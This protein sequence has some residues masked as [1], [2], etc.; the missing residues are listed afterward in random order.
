MDKEYA[1]AIF[2]GIIGTQNVMLNEP[3]KNHTSFRVGGPVDLL[4]TPDSMDNLVRIFEIC[5]HEQLPVFIMGNGT[6]L[7]VR[8]KGIRGIVIKMLD[9]LSSYKVLD[10]TI[11]AEAGILISRLSKIAYEHGLSGMEFAEGIPGTLGGAVTMNAGA[12][13]GEIADVLVR[14]RYL[15]RDGQVI[16]LEKEQ[17]RFGKRESFIQSDGG[18]VLE[19]E[20]KLKKGEKAEIKALM[21]S[22]KKQRNDKQP[23]DLPSAGS[24]FKRPDG[25]FAGKLVQDCG[26][27][28]FRIG[29]AE[30]S[31]KHCGFI[32]NAGNA[33]ACDVINL[34]KHIQ[35]SVM[36]KFHV[37]LQTEVKII[38]E[39]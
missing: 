3:M 25:Y 29:E 6:N 8:D 23:L 26:L 32:V 39:E 31:C 14:S 30:V 18:I 5:R 34:V 11:I 15:G 20:L 22:F 16:V 36:D 24:V 21:D 9:N 35:S 10:D 37:E 38:G 7:V 2:A 28:G 19:T 4:V 12:Y 13:T 17:H 1:A 33:S 27:K